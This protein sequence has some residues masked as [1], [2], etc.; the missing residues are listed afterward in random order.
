[1]LN[2]QC[3]RNL[4]WAKK[5]VC[6]ICATEYQTLNGFREHMAKNHNTGKE[7][8]LICDKCDFTAPLKSI[9]LSLICQIHLN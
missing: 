1:M 6:E 9:L 5:H 2:L 8:E 3:N 7:A 4:K